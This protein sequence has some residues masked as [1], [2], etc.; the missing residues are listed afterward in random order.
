MNLSE[1]VKNS[2]ASQNKHELQALLLLVSTINPTGIIEVGVDRG[3]SIEVWRKAFPDSFITGIDNNPTACFK[4]CDQSI[5]NDS[6]LIDTSFLLHD[7]DFLFIDGDHTEVGV[8]SDFR[9]YS[10]LVRPGGIIA[11]HDVWLK[12]H[13]KVEVYKFWN[14]LKE[15]TN[16]CEIHFEGGTGTGVV[17]V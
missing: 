10:P 9:R 5:I 2:W 15:V 17:F 14:E 13:D 16:Y 8:R 11:L 4:D 1:V 12:N 7:F 3:G 6:K